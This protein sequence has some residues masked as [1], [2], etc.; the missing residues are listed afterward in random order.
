MNNPQAMQQLMS[1]PMVQSLFN[2]PEL[3]RSMIQMN[4]Q[5]RELMEVRTT[6]YTK[7]YSYGKVQYTISSEWLHSQTILKST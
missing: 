2:N 6:A 5:M 3:M 1:S 4:P 7:L